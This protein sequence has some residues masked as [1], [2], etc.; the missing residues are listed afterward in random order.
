VTFKSDFHENGSDSSLWPKRLARWQH[1][2]LP[3]LAPSK[4]LGSSRWFKTEY[5]WAEHASMACMMI[6]SQM[7]FQVKLLE[8]SAT[9]V[10][11]SSSN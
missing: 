2:Q 4:F 9:T 11:T 7:A 3:K 6:P 1:Q 8:F 10:T 5:N